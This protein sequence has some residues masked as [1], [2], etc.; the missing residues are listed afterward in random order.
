MVKR[1]LPNFL[2]KEVKVGDTLYFDM[3]SFCSG[4]YSA[5]VQKDDQGF[6]IDKKDD[7]FIKCL[8]YR[9]N[10]PYWVE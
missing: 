2:Q 9:I 4:S 3:P 8:D 6:Y 10:R 5:K 7:F 1:Y